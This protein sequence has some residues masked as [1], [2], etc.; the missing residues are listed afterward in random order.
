[1]SASSNVKSL[2]NAGL[3]LKL[4]A[5]LR[6]VEGLVAYVEDPERR[7]RFEEKAERIRRRIAGLR[8]EPYEG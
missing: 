3:A 1:M 7:G 5:L 8:Q 6:S 4:E 2:A